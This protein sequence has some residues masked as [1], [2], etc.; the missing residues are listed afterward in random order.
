M[1]ITEMY[2]TGYQ[3]TKM[4]NTELEK[5]GIKSIPPQMIYNYMKKKY[6]PT[7][8]IDNQVVVNH[9]DGIEFMNKYVQKKV[10]V[11]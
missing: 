2:F 1:E 10:S 9:D 3:L 8:V 7:V 5:Y 11:K 4:I 6:I